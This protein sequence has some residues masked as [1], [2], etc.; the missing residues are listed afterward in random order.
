MVDKHTVRLL[1][2][3]RTR[4]DRLAGP[5]IFERGLLRTDPSL[6]PREVDHML[7]AQDFEDRIQ[8]DLD[9]SEPL[10]VGLR[11][12][13]ERL[14]PPCGRPLTLPGSPAT[15]ASSPS[16]RAWMCP[17][18]DRSAAISFPVVSGPPVAD[19]PHRAT[20]DPDKNQF[21][22][23]TALELPAPGRGRPQHRPRRRGRT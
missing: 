3:D 1:A 17:R 12:P 21:E 22:V 13:I 8:R 14:G 4:E 10:K 11:P 9:S 19:D 23:V 15:S 7:D 6:G 18:T 5:R 20:A 16:C 2:E